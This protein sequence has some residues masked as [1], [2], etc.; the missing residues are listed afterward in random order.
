MHIDKP[1]TLQV[2]FWL[3]RRSN[4]SF[5]WTWFYSQRRTRRILCT[6]APAYLSLIV[7]QYSIS[8]QDTQSWPLRST[9]LKS[10]DFFTDTTSIPW[11]TIIHHSIR[12]RIKHVLQL[13]VIILNNINNC[14]SL[15]VFKNLM[16]W[17]ISLEKKI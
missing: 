7:R 15:W 13:K 17:N 16:V 11:I 5:M 3:Y 12:R 4:I 8:R 2:S 6:S 14:N 9:D 10:L 1:S